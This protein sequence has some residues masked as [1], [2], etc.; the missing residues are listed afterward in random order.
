MRK[1]QSVAAIKKFLVKG[2]KL[3]IYFVGLVNYY[4]K[5]L[6]YGNLEKQSIP[7][8]PDARIH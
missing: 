5:K 8:L 4:R 1:T 6:D 7:S 2:N 3:S